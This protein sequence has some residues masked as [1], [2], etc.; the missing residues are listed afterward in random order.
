MSLI[1]RLKRQ[2]KL[3]E[4]FLGNW[5]KPFSSRRRFFI[6]LSKSIGFLVLWP[7]EILGDLLFWPRRPLPQK[8]NRLLII[9]T[10]QLGDVLFSTILP[11]KIKAAYP[12]IQIDY[13]VSQSAA[14]IL[15]NNP[16]VS[17]IY[18]WHNLALSLLPGRNQKNNLKNLYQ[19]WRENKVVWEILKNNNYDLAINA[20]AFWPSSNFRWRLIAKHLIAFDLSQLSF[21]ADNSA[22][23]KLRK[24]EWQNY[25]QLLKPIL[26]NLTIDIKN[27]PAPSFFNVSPKIFYQTPYLCLSPVSFDKERTWSKKQW[28]ELLDLLLPMNYQLILLGLPSQRDWLA[29][30]HQPNDRITILS[31]LKLDELAAAIKGASAF[32]GLDSFSAHLA[33]ALNK[34]AICLVNTKLFYVAGL[35]RQKIVDG[36]CML[37][38][39]KNM[40]LLDLNQA[41]PNDIIQ[42]LSGYNIK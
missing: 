37:A 23:Y 26:P 41:N 3:W 5:R 31:D 2:G 20:R 38:I 10:D 17:S 21:L 1:S 11:Q 27:P 8:I 36:R 6:K 13:L 18:H 19:R 34:P 24:E 4:K 35:S 9:K 32:I 42:A 16:L 39:G 28:Q 22:D 30:I 7:L 40:R 25:Y 29:S 33:Q 12:D 15:T 14:P